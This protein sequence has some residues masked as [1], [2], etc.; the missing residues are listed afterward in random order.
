MRLW[1][2]HP[3][4]L[5]ARGLVA[6]WREA[7]LARAVLQGKTRGYRRHPQL[8]RFRRHPSPRAAIS[9]Y[10]RA[11]HAEAAR[12]GY[13]FDAGKIGRGR[14]LRLIPVTAG[15]LAHEWRHLLR[16]LSARSPAWRRQW[17]SM[18]A[19]RCHPFMRRRAGKVEPWERV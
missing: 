8:D 4:Y 13:S 10:L 17:R 16:K 11:I 14:S 5:D 3:R 6:L 15:Q 12:R 18:R 2:V 9:T 19:P 7:L 1:S